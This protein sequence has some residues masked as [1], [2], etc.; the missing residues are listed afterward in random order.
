MGADIVKRFVCFLVFLVAMVPIGVGAQSIPASDV[1][2]VYFDPSGSAVGHVIE[3]NN[4]FNMF[5][6][7]SNPSSAEVWGFEF[8]YQLEGID[9]SDHIIRLDN[10][11]PLN[12]IDLGDNGDPASG[13]YVVELAEP[14]QGGASVVLVRWQ[15]VLLDPS[16]VY[17]QLGPSSIQS[18]FDGLPAYEGGGVTIPMSL[19]NSCAGEGRAMI[20][21]SCALAVESKTFG[22]LKALYR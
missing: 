17:I 4:P 16:I 11:L 10:V 18:I 2:G 5:V 19:A 22:A 3:P 20:N 6:V 21:E 15:F 12:A 8:G 13:D 14:L 7:L 9:L 1:V